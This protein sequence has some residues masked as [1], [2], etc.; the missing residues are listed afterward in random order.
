RYTRARLSEKEAITG[1]KMELKVRIP[2]VHPEYFKAMG[3]CVK[4]RL[5]D[6]II[7]SNFM[8]SQPSPPIEHYVYLCAGTETRVYGCIDGWKW[9]AGIDQKA[10]AW[11][12][13]HTPSDLIKAYSNYEKKAADGIFIYQADLIT[14]NPYLNDLFS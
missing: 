3:L 6:G 7:P 11:T 8:T 9:L 4:E 14:A 10:G 12:M 5:L 2:A 1:R 13:A